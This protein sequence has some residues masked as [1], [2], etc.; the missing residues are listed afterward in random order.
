MKDE[1]TQLDLCPSTMLGLF[2][3]V[4]LSMVDLVVTFGSYS[5]VGWIWTTET[6]RVLE[7]Q[8]RGYKP[9]F[10]SCLNQFQFQHIL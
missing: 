1:T 2:F 5:L 7:I 10:S 3:T 6:Q 4:Y 9:S 8:F